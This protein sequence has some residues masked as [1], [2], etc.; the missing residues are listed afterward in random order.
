MA[1]FAGVH[2]SN[3]RVALFPAVCCAEALPLRGGPFLHARLA[4]GAKAAGDGV[5]GELEARQ[6]LVGRGVLAG[7]PE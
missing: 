7:G 2:W 5:D 1:S 4:C 3:A 6:E